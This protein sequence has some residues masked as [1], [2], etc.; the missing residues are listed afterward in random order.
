LFPIIPFTTDS[1]IPYKYITFSY[2]EKMG[3]PVIGSYPVNGFDLYRMNLKM[4]KKV[5]IDDKGRI[6]RVTDVYE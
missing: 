6:K 4:V 2:N 3:T 5:M 1:D